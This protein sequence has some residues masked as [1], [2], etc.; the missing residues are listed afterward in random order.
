MFLEEN[1][2]IAAEIEV[3]LRQRLFDTDTAD[4][5]T[6]AAV[7]ESDAIEDELEADTT[8]SRSHEDLDEDFPV[9]EEEK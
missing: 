4:D 5:S 3:K 9:L 6:D 1:P 7:D 8:M 2:A